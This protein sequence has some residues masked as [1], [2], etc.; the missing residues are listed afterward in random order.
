MAK[1]DND[2]S[3]LARA[4]ETLEREL[5][6]LEALSKAVR[7]IRLNSEKNI[8][9]ASKEL[10]ETLAFPERLA[11]GLQQLA[12]AMA[13]MQERQQAALEPLAAFATEIQARMQRLAEHMQA[14]A[15]LGKAAGDVTALLQSERA[16]NGALSAEVDAQLS[17][18]S[19]GARVLFDAAHADDFP[20]VSREADSLKQ[21][22]SALR[23]RLEGRA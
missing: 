16:A 12:A 17:K 3:D 14:Y 20:E 21:R 9:R 1:G 13:R 2:V 15:A 10:S 4:A 19:E 7:K 11:Q 8:A 18:I 6:A 22:V 5:A 23:K